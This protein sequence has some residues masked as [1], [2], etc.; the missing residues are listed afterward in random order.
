MKLNVLE[1]ITLMQILPQEGTYASYK[2]FTDLR[3][4][5]S[6]NEEEYKR[7]GMHETQGQITWQKSEDRDFLFGEKAISII[8]ESLKKLDEAGK[9]TL[10]TSTLYEKFVEKLE[11]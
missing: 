3:A 11:V 2:I 8:Q 9:I 4:Q 5:L 6:F 1:R 7:F 10:Q